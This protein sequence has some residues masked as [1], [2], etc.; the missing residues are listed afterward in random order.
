[1]NHKYEALRGLDD[2]TTNPPRYD[3]YVMHVPYKYVPTIY[4]VESEFKSLLFT[5][6]IRDPYSYCTCYSHSNYP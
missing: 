2:H 1:M 6:F 3:A 5:E 4:W